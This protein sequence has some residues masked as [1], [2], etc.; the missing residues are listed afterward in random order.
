MQNS[1][2]SPQVPGAAPAAAGLKATNKAPPRRKAWLTKEAACSIGL[3]IL[4]IGFAEYATYAKWVSP[5]VMPRPSSVA[6]VL[7][8]GIVDGYF[9]TAVFSSFTSLLVGFLLAFVVAITLAGIISSSRFLEGVFTPY[10]VAIQSLPKVAIAP[11]VVLWLGFG[12]LSKVTIVAVVCFFPIMVNTVQGLRVRALDHDELMRSLGASRWQQFRY[13]RLPHAIP[14]IFA[15]IHIGVIFALIGVVVAEFVGTNSGIGFAML[16]AKSQF[17]V[18]AVYA[19][20]A[21]LMLMGLTLHFVTSFIERRVAAL[22]GEAPIVQ[23]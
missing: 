16:Q 13:M 6:A 21:L 3:A 1:I 12:E 22:M 8:G 18:P 9:L 14:Y 15:G 11:L 23:H 4:L 19:C 17:D 2:R 7:W 20:L 5:M 10:I